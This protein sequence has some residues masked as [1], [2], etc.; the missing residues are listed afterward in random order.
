MTP[1]MRQ[2]PEWGTV[3]KTSKSD[4][5]KSGTVICK[6]RAAYLKNQEAH[7]D[8]LAFEQPLRTNY[9]LFFMSRA[10][11]LGPISYQTLRS[12]RFN[13]DAL[14][15]DVIITYNGK[16][17]TASRLYDLTFIFNDKKELITTIKSL[18]DDDARRKELSENAYNIT[19]HRDNISDKIIDI[20]SEYIN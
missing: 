20:I 16:N 18:L 17:I 2:N 3:I 19:T 6:N 7:A 5:R 9:T 12:H 4:K 13:F 14:H 11:A 10:L 15:K 1:K 8:K